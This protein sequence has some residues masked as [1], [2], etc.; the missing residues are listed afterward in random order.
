MSNDGSKQ[1][2]FWELTEAHLQEW[3]AHPVTLSLLQALQA[4]MDNGLKNCAEYVAEG[5]IGQGAQQSGIAWQSE[6]YI[7]GIAVKRAE[8]TPEDTQDTTYVDR[9]TRLSTRITTRP[10]HG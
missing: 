1:P 9:A 2:S 5:Q 10:T 4:D 6:R 3:R 8:R 7:K